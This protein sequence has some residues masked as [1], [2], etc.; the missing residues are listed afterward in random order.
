MSMGPLYT[1][2]DHLVYFDTNLGT[3][4]GQS[5]QWAALPFG[6]L[7]PVDCLPPLPKPIDNLVGGVVAG[8]VGGLAPFLG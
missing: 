5:A 7:N 4:F 8:A 2:V 3:V 1:F 6:I